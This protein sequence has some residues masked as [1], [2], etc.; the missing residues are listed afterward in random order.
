MVKL[1]INKKNLEVIFKTVASKASVHS[2][3]LKRHIKEFAKSSGGNSSLVVDIGSG[4][5]P[6]KSLFHF[7]R[8]MSIDVKKINN[9]NVIGDIC[10]LPVK[11][12]I[13]D[14]IICT[15][16]L[17]HVKNSNKAVSELNRVLKDGKYLILTTPLLI[18]V[19]DQIDFFRFTE[20]GLKN[21]LENSGFEILEIKK[22]G[23]IFSSLGGLLTHIPLQVFSYK[24]KKNYFKFGLIFLYYLLL[25]PINRLLIALD[26]IDKNRNYTLGYDLLL[27]KKAISTG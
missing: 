12:N 3:Y 24:N 9:V 14:I 17:E 6:Y 13:A 21:L 25:I 16:V 27:R 1:R 22:R 26:V 11:D 23:G 20:L 18:G 8:Y 2:F 15:E 4:T 5:S 19:H 10:N 7:E